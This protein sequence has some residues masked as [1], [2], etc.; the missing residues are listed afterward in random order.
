MRTFLNLFFSALFLFILACDEND[1]NI[2]SVDHRS[3]FDFKFEGSGSTILNNAKNGKAG[4]AVV[5][6][7]VDGKVGRAVKFLE[8]GSK[9]KLYGKSGFPFDENITF[10]MWYKTENYT[11][12]RQQIFGA[13]TGSVNSFPI[14]NFG[15]GLINDKLVFDL[16]TS[17]GAISITSDPLGIENNV[18]VLL[19]ITWDGDQLIFYKNGSLL[20]EGSVIVEFPNEEDFNNFIGC[21]ER[22]LGGTNIENQLYGIIDEFSLFNGHLSAEE[23]LQYYN[24]TN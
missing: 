7:R 9:I 14:N 20:T 11:T 21:N 5:L 22:V 13:S 10:M 18:W 4:E 16:Q 17:N 24:D 12:A 3:N 8:K 6:S 15:I 23:I 2:V 19:A 1:D